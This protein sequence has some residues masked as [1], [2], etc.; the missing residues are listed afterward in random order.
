[1]QEQDF[2]NFIKNYIDE[3]LDT[4]CGVGLSVTVD[5]EKLEKLGILSV[6][7]KENANKVRVENMAI[8][9]FCQNLCKKIT[10]YEK[11]IESEENKNGEN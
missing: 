6:D 3:V 11:S 2:I 5:L 8:Y 10:E 9:T 4:T 7:M 1:M